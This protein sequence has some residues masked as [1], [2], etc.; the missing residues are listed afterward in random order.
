MSL[1]LEH[2]SKLARPTGSRSRC[3]ALA[4]VC[5]VREVRKVVRVGADPARGELDARSWTSI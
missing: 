1:D 2:A 5:D 4:K 3:R